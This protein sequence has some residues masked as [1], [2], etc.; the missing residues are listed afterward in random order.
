MIAHFRGQSDPNDR[1]RAYSLLVTTDSATPPEGDA[2]PFARSDQAPAGGASR[3]RLRRWAA[4]A[5]L[6]A[7]FA[8]AVP[9]VAASGTTKK[10][11]KPVTIVRHEKVSAAGTYVVVVT[12]APPT[13]S[14]TINVFA[15]GQSQ[16]N[17]AVTPSQGATLAFYVHLS[18]RTFNVRIVGQGRSP[19]FTVASALQTSSSGPTGPTGPTG[20]SGSTG[21]TGATGPTIVYGPTT[22]PYNKLVW[23]D[24]FTGTAGTPPN[25]AYWTAD[26]GG[27]CGDGTLTTNTADPRPARSTATGT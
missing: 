18:H 5:V 6:L 27:G 12:V 26:S 2:A 21:S 22:G 8:A 3:P 14:Q 9:S 16:K 4:L 13:A 11:P 1:L 10:P 7:G 24:E 25:P 23:D 19:H 20:A 15:N 17:I